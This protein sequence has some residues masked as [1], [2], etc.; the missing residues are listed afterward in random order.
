MQDEEIS[1]ESRVV[2]RSDSINSNS[3]C[4]SDFG[5]NN[6]TNMIERFAGNLSYL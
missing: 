1:L 2:Q 6:S 4:H 5:N 3:T